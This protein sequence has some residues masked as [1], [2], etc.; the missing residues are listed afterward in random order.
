[1]GLRARCQGGETGEHPCPCGSLRSAEAPATHQGSAAREPRGQNSHRSLHQKQ[2][3]YLCPHSLVNA[4]LLEAEQLLGPLREQHPNSQR[5][6][7]GEH[8]GIRPP[9]SLSVGTWGSSS[10][11]QKGA[12]LILG[13]RGP[14]VRCLPALFPPLQCHLNVREKGTRSTSAPSSLPP[15]GWLGGQSLG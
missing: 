14:Q 3:A 15:Q 7:L 1:M 8:V 4:A 6:P 12:L 9:H 2:A 11:A 13:A 5:Q 10:S